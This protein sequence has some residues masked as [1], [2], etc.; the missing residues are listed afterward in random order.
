[1]KDLDLHAFKNRCLSAV[2]LKHKVGLAEHYGAMLCEEL[3]LSAP[4]KEPSAAELL[5][6]AEAVLKARSGKG[7]AGV[8]AVQKAAKKPGKKAE[9]KDEGLKAFEGPAVVHAPLKADGKTDVSQDLTKALDV[10]AAAPLSPENE[11]KA[12]P[13]EPVRPAPAETAV[14][15][16]P[17]GA[18]LAETP[19]AAEELETAIVDALF[20]DDDDISKFI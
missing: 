17:E 2:L 13:V 15:V 18:S 11:G 16:V 6:L 19:K 20:D 5:D 10:A 4:E 7:A 8:K 14:A 3:G 9:K 1:M 12:L